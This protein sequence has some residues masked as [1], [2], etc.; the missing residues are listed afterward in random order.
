[1]LHLYWAIGSYHYTS[2]FTLRSC[3]KLSFVKCSRV[4]TIKRIVLFFFAGFVSLHFLSA[5]DT[6]HY[7]SV[8]VLP[9]P[10]IGYS[11]ETKTYVGAVTLFTFDFYRDSLTRLSNA[12]A[13]F[14]YTWNRQLI[15]DVGWNIFTRQEKWFTSGQFQYAKYPEF[16]YGTGSDTPDDNKVSYSSRRVAFEGYALKNISRKWFTG[17]NIKYRQYRDVKFTRAAG[18]DYPELKDGS[19]TGVGIAVLHDTRNNLLTPLSGMYAFVNGTLNFAKNTYLDA[20]FDL[21]VYQTWQNKYTTALRWYNEITAG[22]PPFF[23]YALLGGDRF[24]RGYYSGRYRDKNLS[25][26]QLEFRFPVVWRFGMAAFGGVSNVFSDVQ[27]LTMKDS[28][29]NGGL[30]LRFMV[31]K[32]DRTNLRIDYAKGNGSNSGFY[33][34][35]GESF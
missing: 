13:E 15:F 20:V 29:Y 19:V 12:R 35:F 1:M 34:A 11:P 24:V 17:I 23:D 21:R 33:I 8:K 27:H 4:N 28:K 32:K 16:Y 14:N 6:V 25:T 7:R 18:L 30:G 2:V 3:N 9:V 26:V 31:D 5:Q 22:S 10:A